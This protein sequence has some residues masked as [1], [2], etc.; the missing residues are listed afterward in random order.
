LENAQL[1]KMG[2]AMVEQIFDFMVRDMN[3][4]I[5]DLQGK[6]AL[7]TEQGQMIL[8]GIRKPHV[9]AARFTDVWNA[10]YALKDAYVN[11]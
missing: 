3:Q 11:A 8:A 1:H 5:A 2:A 10:V 4:F 6:S 7:T 9:D